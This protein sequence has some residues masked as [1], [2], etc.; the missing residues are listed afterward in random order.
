MILHI[1]MDAFF[2]SVEQ[3]D[4][5]E[6][7]NKPIVVS[8]HSKRSVVSTASYEARKFGIHSA[9]PVFMA[10]QRCKNLII[11]SGNREKYKSDSNKIMNILSSISPLV[12]PVSIDE[13]YIDIKGLKRLYGSPEDIAEKI[14][15]RIYTQLGLTCSIGIAPVKFLSKIASDM[16]KP[17]GLTIILEEQVERFITGLP[18]KKVPGIG[19]TALKQMENLQIKTLGDI[20]QFSL[21]VLTK[22][23]GKMGG[24]LLDLSNG[25]DSS[26]VD[27]RSIRKSIS[28]ETTLAN[29]ISD[30]ESIKQILLDRAQV[31]GATLRKKELTC[32]NIFIKLKFSDFSQITR[33]RKLDEPVCSSSAIFDQALSLFGKIRLNKK[34]RLAG[35]GV[36][37]LKGKDAPVQLSLLPDDNPKK[38]QWE[39]VDFAVDSI[40]EKFGTYAVKKAS[41]NKAKKGEKGMK[42]LI[43]IQII[44]EGMVQGVFYRASTRDAAEKLGVKGWVKNMPDR[45]VHALLQGKPE[46]LEKMIVWCRQ[47]PP[48]SRVDNVHTETIEIKEKYNSF[49]VRY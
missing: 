9:M 1:D 16:N 14:K 15:K 32:S 34:I 37:S 29:D 20:R 18:I 24:R 17:D 6:L 48:A 2:A 8:G 39:S 38:K 31:V 7:R 25:I 21:P 12:E 11:V 40:S 47:G 45:T 4:H 43:Q 5:P 27:T 49:E 3:R 30:F 36:S 44:V 28:S 23:F 26:R 19:K 33:S 35:V 13:A 46:I 42:N 22:K 10:R 41:L